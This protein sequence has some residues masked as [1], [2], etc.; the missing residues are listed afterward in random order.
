[1]QFALFSINYVV[2]PWV[3]AEGDVLDDIQFPRETLANKS[4]DCDD[5]SVL[6]A[7]LA[8]KTL[9]LNDLNLAQATMFL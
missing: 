9:A 2:D 7:C 4:G 8:L 1:M 3:V 6:L 5:T